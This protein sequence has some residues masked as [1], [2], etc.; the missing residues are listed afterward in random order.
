MG[1]ALEKELNEKKITSSNS[2]DKMVELSKKNKHIDNTFRSVFIG[3]ARWLPF[4][5]IQVFG[6]TVIGLD[7]FVKG[8]WNWEYLLSAEFWNRFINYQLAL[9]IVGISWFMNIIVRLIKEHW[10]YRENLSKIKEQVDYDHN[11]SE[12]IEKQVEIEKLIR[13]K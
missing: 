8:D 11:D 7:K 5:G 13:K 6:F 9:W 2:L 12:F 1:S 4:V 3:V 10:E